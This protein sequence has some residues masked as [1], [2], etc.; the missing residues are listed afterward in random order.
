M[1]VDIGLAAYLTAWYAGNYYYNIYNKSAAKAGGGAEFAFTMALLQLV[2]GSIYALFL[3]IAPEARPM[4]KLSFNQILKLAPM[5][6]YA[7]AAHCGAVYS[8]SAGAVSFAQVIKAAEPAF[9]AAVGFLFYGQKV[10]IAKLCCLV[11]II[12]G[13]VLASVTELDFTYKA[14]IAASSANVAAAFRGQETKRVMADPSLK[15]AVGGPG[16]AYALTTLWATLILIPTLF[17]SGEASQK[18]VFK[19]MWDADGK[20]GT[21]GNF[22]WNLF[23]SGITFYLYN[24]V[25]TLA[26]GKISGVTHSVANTAKRAIIIV[27]CAIAFGESM[28]PVKMAGCTIAILGTFLYAVADDLFG[29]KKATAAKKKK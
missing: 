13:I 16:N 19:A 28:A 23:M 15:T 3:W 20:K 12:G 6:F 7:A 17:I 8:L 27:G 25:S 29:G 22:R 21:V 18:D 5:G 10:S 26:L 24:G 11:P 9:A 1:G 2:F 4:P 14:L